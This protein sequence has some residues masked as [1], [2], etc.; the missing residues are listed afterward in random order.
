MINEIENT[1]TNEVMNRMI[2]IQHHKHEL[3]FRDLIDL[4]FVQFIVEISLE[5]EE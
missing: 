1:L 3:E 4:W 2:I 5:G